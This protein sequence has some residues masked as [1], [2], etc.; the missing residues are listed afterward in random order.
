[1]AGRRQRGPKPSCP[2]RSERFPVFSWHQPEVRFLPRQFHRPMDPRGLLQPGCGL[3]RGTLG[4]DA[5]R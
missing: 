3:L 1:M 5:L 4:T 2:I